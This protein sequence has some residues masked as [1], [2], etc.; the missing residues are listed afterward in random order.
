ME[1]RQCAFG[2]SEQWEDELERGED[3]VDSMVV[4][5]SEVGDGGKE[6]GERG[7]RT[8]TLEEVCEE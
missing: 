7:S 2:S 6:R 8:C 5:E 1:L 4:G 3:W